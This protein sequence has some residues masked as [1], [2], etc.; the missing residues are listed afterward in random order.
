MIIAD[1]YDEARLEAIQVLAYYDNF[2]S[3]LTIDYDEKRDKWIIDYN[4][5]NRKIIVRKNEFGY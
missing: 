3:F 4:D 1:T 2:P 5:E